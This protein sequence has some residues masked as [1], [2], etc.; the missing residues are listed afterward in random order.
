MKT[1]VS[2]DLIQ[3]GIKG[4][5]EIFMGGIKQN[6]IILLEGSPGTGKTTLGLEFI[7]RGAKELKENGLI[8]S[9]ELSPQKLLRDAKGFGWDLDQLQKKNKIKIIYTSPMVVLQE[10]QSP[11]SVLINE[12]KSLGAKRI[13]IDGLTPL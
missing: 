11:N 10:L 8:I 3:T 13:L 5:D 4:L 9:F 6:N 1:K 7:Y 12:I 2:K